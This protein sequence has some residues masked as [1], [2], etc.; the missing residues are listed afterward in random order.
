MQ[1][2]TIQANTPLSFLNAYFPE[3]IPVSETLVSINGIDCFEFRPESLPTD[4]CKEQIGK[5]VVSCRYSQLLLYGLFRYGTVMI[6]CE[7]EA[8][9]AAA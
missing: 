6:P 8:I 2:I 1:L 5:A 9:Y 7:L 4:D 3:G